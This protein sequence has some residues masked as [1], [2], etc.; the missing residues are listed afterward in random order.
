MAEGV[1][2]NREQA[3]RFLTSPHAEIGGK[4]PVDAALTESGARQAEEL[5]ARILY[6]LPA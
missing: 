4:T 2:E 1:W 5:M 3:R 6:G